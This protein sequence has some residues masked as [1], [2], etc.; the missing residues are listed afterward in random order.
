MVPKVRNRAQSRARK[1][2]LTGALVLALMLGAVLVA[3]KAFDTS[4]ETSR[5]Q[6]RSPKVSKPITF[7]VLADYHSCDYGEGQEELVDAVRAAHP[8]AV[9]MAG[10]MADDDLP[11]GNVLELFSTLG[12]EYPC[13]YVTGNH[14]WRRKDL[15]QLEKQFASRGIT[16]LAG[17]TVELTV[18]GQRFHYQDETTLFV[19]RGLSRES[20][21]MPRFYNRPEL[22]I[23][24][25]EPE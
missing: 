21:I 18:N 1:V 9:L 19:S 12:K 13:Y 15:P 5:F 7:V 23:L 2:F 14:E 25:V 20:T 10:D 17:D 3:T 24:T 22:A 6:L 8:D 11:S 4:L 16:I